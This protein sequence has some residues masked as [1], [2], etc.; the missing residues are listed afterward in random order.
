[1]REVTR[2]SA[3]RIVIWRA[4]PAPPYA[5]PPRQPSQRGSGAANH[6]DVRAWS[7]SADNNVDSDTVNLKVGHPV[8]NQPIMPPRCLDELTTQPN[9]TLRGV[10]RL[11]MNGMDQQFRFGNGSSDVTAGSPDRKVRTFGREAQDQRFERRVA[12]QDRT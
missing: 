10:V 5:R 3:S 1:M 11:M 6:Q 4:R 9:G 7:A 8:Y 2:A 12:E